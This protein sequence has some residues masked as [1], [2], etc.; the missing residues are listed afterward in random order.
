MGR[1]RPDFL[2]RCAYDLTTSLCTGA[3]GLVSDGRKSF[4]SGHSSSAFCGLGFLFFFLASKTAVFTHARRGE[5]EKD[6]RSL[7]SKLLRLLIT[8]SPL[9]VAAWIAVSRLEDEFHHP[10]DVLAGSFIGLV[11]AYLTYVF[12]WPSPFGS[13]RPERMARPRG[14]YGEAM[15]DGVEMFAGDSESEDEGADRV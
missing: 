4:P 2:S 6:S 7:G 14:T 12:Y 1:L 11:I 10:T 15:D 9:F 13:S 3:P 5:G 8:I